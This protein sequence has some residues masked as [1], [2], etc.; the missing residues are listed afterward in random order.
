MDEQQ[1]RLSYL[2]QE[3]LVWEERLNR[4]LD[5]E[6]QRLTAELILLE[7]RCRQQENQVSCCCP[8]NNGRPNLSKNFSELQ[9]KD[10]LGVE[11][12]WEEA[13]R[14]GR[15]MTEELARLRADVSSMDSRMEQYEPTLR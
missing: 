7:D 4:R 15:E 1:D 8:R 11:D 6:R 2:E 10:L 12:E 5:D 13:C 9:L 14:E 3:L